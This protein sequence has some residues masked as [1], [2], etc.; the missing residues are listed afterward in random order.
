[1]RLI[2][3]AIPFLI[4]ACAAETPKSSQPIPMPKPI[5]VPGPM[6]T[7]PPPAADLT[8]LTIK[9]LTPGSGKEAVSGKPVL[10]HYTG[11]LYDAAAPD[12]KGKQFDSSRTRGT[13]FGFT[14]GAGQVI[15]GWDQGVPGMKVGGKR[16][17]IIPPSMGYGDRGAGGVIP[18]NAVLVFDVELMDVKN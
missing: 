14:P 11:W 7:T 4:A 8:Q 3:F 5:G 17:L 13:P 12:L 10:V 9:E 1:M 15:K 2:A 6:T 16:L 18:P